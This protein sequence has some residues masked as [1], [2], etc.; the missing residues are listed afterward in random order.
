MAPHT[1]PTVAQ[2]A[3]LLAR[4][5]QL[6]LS[7]EPNRGQAPRQTRFLARGAGYT[8]SLTANG[9]TLTLA[10]PAQVSRDLPPSSIKAPRASLRPHLVTQ[11]MNTHMRAPVSHVVPLDTT[12]PQGVGTPIPSPS[13]TAAM[14]PTTAPLTP[15]SPIPSPSEIAVVTPTTAPFTPTSP[16][17]ETQPLTGTALVQTRARHHLHHAHARKGKKRHESPAASTTVQLAFV[18]ANAQP[19]I[20]GVDALPGTDNYLLGRQR[21]Q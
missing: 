5:A 18:G 20:V 21:A 14:T 12:G 4:Y 10:A 15:A 7:F 1:V 11:A 8:L 13:G 3:R 9:A 6:P 17:T 2:R 19:H 16:I